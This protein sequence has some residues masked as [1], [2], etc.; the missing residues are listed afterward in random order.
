MELISQNPFEEV[1]DA[2]F[3]VIPYKSVENY[4]SMASELVS[5]TLS[6]RNLSDL[7]LILSGAFAPLN[8]FMNKKDYDSVLE[9]MRLANGVLWPMPVVLEV[10]RRL[11]ST[12]KP[13]QEIALR[14]TQGLLLA[15]LLVNDVWKPN[16]KHEALAVYQS[17]DENHPGL[18]KLFHEVK[19]F[20]IGGE[21]IPLSSPQH[22]NFNH[23]RFTPAQLKEK[24]QQHGWKKI[25]AFHTQALMHKAERELTLQAAKITGAKCLIHPVVAQPQSG[26]FDD[27]MR[28]R[29]Y[30][31]LIKT[32]PSKSAILALLPLT[33][34]M[35]GPRE[36]LWHAIIRKNYGCTH[37]IIGRDHASPNGMQQEQKYYHSYEAQTLALSYQSEI[38]IEIVPLHEPLRRF[39]NILLKRQ[40]WC[41]LMQN[42]SRN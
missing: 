17:L 6:H 12:V 40:P 2:I 33:M 13:G 41:Y 8:G 28:V 42:C 25:V 23:L 1:L 32:Y 11:A 14:D 21:V 22:F 36:A 4:Q 34:R 35:A 5:I 16:K 9:N 31:H 3:E 20:Y 37:F 19:D 10:D 30:E 15:I 38:D 26:V 7:E 29:C 18:V 24:F 27:F 39:S